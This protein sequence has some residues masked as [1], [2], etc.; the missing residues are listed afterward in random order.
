MSQLLIR[1]DLNV[2]IDIPE[3]ETQIKN[4]IDSINELH[5]LSYK[6]DRRLRKRQ[7]LSCRSPRPQTSSERSSN[8]K[9]YACF[10]KLLKLVGYHFKQEEDLMEKTNY[11]EELFNEHV[12]H[13][14]EFIKT[15][16]MVRQKYISEQIETI[17]NDVFDFMKN[18]ITDHILSD[19]MNFF[20]FYKK[21]YSTL[22]SNV[23]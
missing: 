15:L 14:L 16:G 22:S 12:Q 1:W 7:Q 5:I 13:H 6:P 10:D 20:N 17:G 11:T 21:K 9:I 18:W 8:D 4:I 2:S 19:D 23:T 3:M